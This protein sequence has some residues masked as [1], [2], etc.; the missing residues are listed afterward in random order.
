MP[1]GWAGSDGPDGPFD[2]PVSPAQQNFLRTEIA[3]TIDAFD[4]I[5]TALAENGARQE[6]LEKAITAQTKQAD[7]LQVF[8]SDMEDADMAE[9]ATRFQQ[10]QTAVDVAAR[11][12]ADLSQVSLLP[13]LR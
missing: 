3:N 7:Y 12:F 6:R 13:F 8:I 5:N 11:T 9:A 2:G 4:T 1:A 10:A